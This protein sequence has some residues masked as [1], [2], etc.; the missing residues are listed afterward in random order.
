MLGGAIT[1]L[2]FPKFILSDALDGIFSSFK[3]QVVEPCQFLFNK[4]HNTGA[5]GV[6][7]GNTGKNKMDYLFMGDSR[8]TQIV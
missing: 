5:F 3:R 2:I 6:A 4:R 7:K 8:A 1:S